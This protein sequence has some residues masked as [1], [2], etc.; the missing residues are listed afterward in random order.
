[1]EY[2]TQSE[3]PQ[4]QSSLG[5]L[6][7]IDKK[8]KY[9]QLAWWCGLAPI[10]LFILTVYFWGLLQLFTTSSNYQT[11]FFQFS[12]QT[13]VPS[14]IVIESIA[15]PIGI[16]LA[17]Y[18]GI[19]ATRASSNPNVIKSKR[20]WWKIVGIIALMVLILII[21]P[22]LS[23]WLVT[24]HYNKTNCGFAGCSPDVLFNIPNTVDVPSRVPA[25]ELR[26][27][28]KAEAR[29]A[30]G[31]VKLANLRSRAKIF[32]FGKLDVS[33]EGWCDVVEDTPPG[34]VV[35]E[36]VDAE[37]SWALSARTT[38]TNQLK[39]VD[40]EN[41][42]VEGGVSAESGLCKEG[43]IQ[44]VT[45]SSDYGENQVTTKSKLSD[46]SGESGELNDSPRAQL[47]IDDFVR[48]QA[49]LESLKNE[50]GYEQIINERSGAVFNTHS[51]LE[52]DF[53]GFCDAI[54]ENYLLTDD[55]VCVDSEQNWAVS[56]PEENG[57]L[58]CV[59]SNNG[60]VDGKISPESGLCKQGEIQS[61][62]ETERITNES[63][64]KIRKV[65]DGLDGIELQLVT[66]IPNL[67]PG[68]TEEWQ[69]MT[70][71]SVGDY[72]VIMISGTAATRAD[73]AAGVQANGFLGELLAVP[74]FDP[75][76]PTSALTQASDIEFDVVVVVTG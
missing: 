44:V 22:A 3:N 57:E 39:C 76:L 7:P 21:I 74:N 63:I 62:A 60:L 73:L 45:T 61:A 24:S 26:E 27:A 15:F 9:R 18:F 72:P 41:G 23:V 43:E 30:L 37:D 47:T 12:N 31:E 68:E 11:A 10:L 19:K 34:L 50:V 42:I 52:L 16:I 56:M 36:C 55:F 17:I 29:D 71:E 14:L 59:D 75:L 49:R 5:Q 54:K 13:L 38:G 66:A 32:A 53:R 58:K 69:G 25:V 8:Q 48:D 51:T 40:S 67:E 4:G 70:F 2:Q 35:N 1:M 28:N 46:V 33:Y 65:A 6:Q 20:N 64:E